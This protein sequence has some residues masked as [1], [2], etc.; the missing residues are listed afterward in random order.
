MVDA[1]GPAHTTPSGS[2]HSSFQLPH[3]FQ[4]LPSEGV[5]SLNIKPSFR[6]CPTSKTVVLGL[7]LLCLNQ[8]GHLGSRAHHKIVLGLSGDHMTIQLFCLPK[9][10]SLS[11]N[12]FS[13]KHSPGKSCRPVSAL[14]PIQQ[15]TQFKTATFFTCFLNPFSSPKRI[16]PSPSLTL[17]VSLLSLV[18]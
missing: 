10:V 1:P 13:Y 18:S 6:K 8:G 11:Y 15:G 17:D 5:A 2:Q 16:F 3:S 12:C 7:G 9:S 14:E 4:Q